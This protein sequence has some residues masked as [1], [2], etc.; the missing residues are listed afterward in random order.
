MRCRRLAL[1]LLTTALLL[2][3]CSGSDGDAT[4]TDPPE[5]TVTTT[6]PD[7]D[8]DT[9]PQQV[10]EEPT[11]DCVNDLVVTGSEADDGPVA[12]VT[13]ITDDGPHPANTVDSDAILSGAVATYALEPDPQF[14]LSIP[15][16]VPEVPDDGLIYLFTLTLDD[17]AGT[18]AAGATFTDAAEGT[19]D[20][21]GRIANHGLYSG[22]S[23][24][25][26]P[27]GPTTIEINEIDDEWVCGTI[28][29]VG[30]TDIQTFPTLNGTFAAERIQALEAEG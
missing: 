6:A 3:G 26:N 9:V 13:A 23:G 14:G 1:A 11:D 10:P 4:D 5:D 7:D 2:T 27:L 16:G 25:I 22:A 21:D 17:T 8:A 20:A 19:E 29:S 28:T 18:I 24:R 30:R 12:V 15:V